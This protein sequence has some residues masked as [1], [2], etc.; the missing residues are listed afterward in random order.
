MGEAG[1]GALGVVE[2]GLGQL[3]AAAQLLHLQGRGWCVS[4]VD[5]GLR[6][7]GGDGG[8]RDLLQADCLRHA[9][10]I[11]CRCNHCRSKTLATTW[12][13]GARVCHAIAIALQTLHFALCGG[14]VAIY[15]FFENLPFV[16]QNSKNKS[17]RR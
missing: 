17:E 16:C 6:W 9:K 10:P 13:A 12:V 7:G 2:D 1:D 14:G 3:Q 11:D 15:D 4:G 8:G 5:G